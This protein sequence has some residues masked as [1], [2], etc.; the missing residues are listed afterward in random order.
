MKNILPISIELKEPL[1]IFLEV[2]NKT[3][4]DDISEEDAKM[5][6]VPPGTMSEVDGEL[7]LERWIFAREEIDDMNR[8]DI[9]ELFMATFGNGRDHYTLEIEVFPATS[10]KVAP[11]IGK[12]NQ[13]L[14]DLLKNN[15]KKG[16][17]GK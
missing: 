9:A 5:I 4:D 14:L 11:Y 16:K 10:N 17:K 7:E 13:S 12:G 8:Y 1:D 3:Y 6:D 15:G 2:V